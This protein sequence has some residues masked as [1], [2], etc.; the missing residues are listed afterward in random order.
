M[1]AQGADASKDKFPIKVE[2]DAE[3]KIQAE[4]FKNRIRVKEF[5]R[6]YDKLR[7]GVVSEAAVF[8]S[9]QDQR[10]ILKL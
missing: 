9:H 3:K 10:Y 8:C 6:D 1:I 5:F 2:L 7:K 4:A